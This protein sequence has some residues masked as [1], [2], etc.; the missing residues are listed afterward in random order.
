MARLSRLLAAGS[1]LAA[2][3]ALAAPALAGTVIASSGPSAGQY[4]VGAQIANTQRITLQANDSLTVLDNG[5]TRVLRG[6]GSFTLS[7]RGAQTTNTAFAALTEQ[8]AAGRARVASVRGP[9]D[10]PVSNPSLW[11]VDV[12]RSG[13]MCLADPARV[14]LWRADASAE[15]TFA[16]TG[17]GE[18]L[19]NV[20]F[21]AS[22]GIAAWDA[23]SPP[24]EGVA[25][26]IGETE[27]T[28]RFLE[29]VPGDA[30]AMAQALIEHGCTLQLEQLA[31]ATMEPE[32]A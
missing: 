8:R 13:T 1:G 11:Y 26:R 2:F 21:P 32:A 29:A 16:I 18:N 19:A 30:E 7:R 23:A 25:Y 20:T 6:P 9:G 12:A 27:V 14:R 28:F 15:A 3:A 4:R 31:S 5:G 24:R 22:E 17:H 10:A